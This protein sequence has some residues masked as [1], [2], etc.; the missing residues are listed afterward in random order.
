MQN[1]PR[2]LWTESGGA[3]AP[4][5]SAQHRHSAVMGRAFRG[6]VKN[7]LRGPQG[8]PLIIGTSGG[9]LKHSFLMTFSSPL[10]LWHE[11][12]RTDPVCRV[13]LRELL[14]SNCNSVSLLPFRFCSVCKHLYWTKTWTQRAAFCN[15]P[16]PHQSPGT[17][18]GGSAQ[19]G[20][21]AAGAGGPA[22]GR[23]VP[24]PVQGRGAQE[25]PPRPLEPGAHLLL[26][27]APKSGN[28]HPPSCGSAEDRW[29][30]KRRGCG[31]RCLLRGPGRAR[32]AALEPGAPPG[33]ELV[34]SLLGRHR[35]K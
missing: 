11:R 12:W 3:L 17:V 30:P 4:G 20:G 21:L 29:L 6:G 27:F 5:G 32:L 24:A 26:Y 23:P 13:C 19:A 22:P 8:Q 14:H 33:G 34:L 16:K 35:L 31:G 9:F 7:S 15:G 1:I 28:R 10:V 2:C 18:R 25:Q